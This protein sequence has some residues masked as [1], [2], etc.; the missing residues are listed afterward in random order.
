MEV[1]SDETKRTVADLE[2]CVEEQRKQLE[3]GD[4]AVHLKTI[5]TLEEVCLGSSPAA[6]GTNIHF[7]TLPPKEKTFNVMLMP[8]QRINMHMIN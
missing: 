6:T 3:Q 1:Q 8:L 2:R 4:T 7:R 5:R